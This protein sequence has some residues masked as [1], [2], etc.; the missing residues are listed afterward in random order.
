[1]SWVGRCLAVLPPIIV[2]PARAWGAQGNMATGAIAY[3]LLAA[4]D[5]AMVA[6][7]EVL[8]EKHPDRARFDSLARLFPGD[9]S[10]FEAGG[11]TR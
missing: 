11:I 1:M 5:P 8:M 9:Q 10:D 4:H 3:D 7:M 6:A 2:S